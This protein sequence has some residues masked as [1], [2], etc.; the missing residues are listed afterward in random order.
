[1]INRRLACAAALSLALVGCDS[2]GP[3]PGT[4]SLRVF[5][6]HFSAAEVQLH[7]ISADLE[8]AITHAETATDA[9]VTPAFSALASRVEHESGALEQL[10]PPARYNTR[11]RAL[12]S[13]LD[14]VASD[15]GEISAAAAAHDARGARSATKALRQDAGNVKSAEITVSESPGVRGG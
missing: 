7:L 2:A 11:L 10:N 3:S 9:Q 8:S 4:S 5:R 1:M 12:A 15:L 14:A 13:A 6:S